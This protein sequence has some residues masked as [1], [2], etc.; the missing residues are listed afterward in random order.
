VARLALRPALALLPLRAFLGVTFVYAGV[1]KLS[2]PGF[3]HPGAS[4]YIGTQLSG[5]AHGTPGGFLLR[6]FAIPHAQLAGVGVAVTEI[7][8]GVLVLAGLATQLAAVVGLSL[9]LV[10]FLTASWKTS[11]YFLGSDIVFAF[12]WLPFVLTG[13]AGQPALDHA[14]ARRPVRAAAN[15]MTR[16]QALAAAWGGAAAASAAIAGLAAALKGRAAMTHTLAAGTPAPTPARRR[17]ARRPRVPAGAVR[18]GS[19]SQLTAG[20]GALYADPADGQADIVVRQPSGAL[21]ACSAICPHAGCRVEYSSGALVCHCHGSV[22]DSHTG[23]VRRGPAVQPLAR[24]R[25]IERDGSI[26][27]LP[28]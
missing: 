7:A 23:A 22:F 5:F 9:N 21:T 12:A 6:T 2:D 15:G 25:V 13:S 1:Q 10:L 20:S 11:P 27:A 17:R 18:L 16:R 28:S 8:V 14:L 4:T 3:L 19:S 26:Y 24:K